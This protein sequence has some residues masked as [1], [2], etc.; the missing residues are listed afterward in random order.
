[1]LVLTLGFQHPEEFLASK[2]SQLQSIGLDIAM[3]LLSP[4]T[5]PVELAFTTSMFGSRHSGGWLFDNKSGT[6]V[7]PRK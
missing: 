2:Y 3:T 4:T 6:R 5:D 1:M 7:T